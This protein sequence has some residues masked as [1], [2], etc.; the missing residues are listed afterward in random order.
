MKLKV[1]WQETILS[2]G[3]DKTRQ[4]RKGFLYLIFFTYF[5]IGKR[6]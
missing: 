4:D 5:C 3:E 1:P 2:K 6:D